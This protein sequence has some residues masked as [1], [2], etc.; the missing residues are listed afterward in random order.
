MELVNEAALE[1][2]K[3]FFI[4]DDC[5]AVVNLL[6]NYDVSKVS[7][8]QFKLFNCYFRT[9]R[10]NEALEL[11]KA[12]VK[13]ENLEDRV[14]WLVNLSKILYKN[15]DYEHAIIAANDALS[16]GS[17]VEYSD[18]TPSLFDRFYS[19][20]ALKRFTEAVSTISA[21]EQLRGQDFKIIE[22]YAAICDYAMKSND[23]A[24]AATYAKKALEL[25]TRAKINTFSPKLNFDYSEASLKTDNIDEA[26]DEAKFILNMKLEPEDRLHALNLASEIYIRQKQYKLAKPYLNE[27]IGSNFTSAYKDACKAKLEM[28]K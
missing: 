16:L 27:C 21:I 18:P 20:L 23:Y 25:Q 8:P 7:L 6:E 10:Y 13:D 14:E 12:H 9:A 19:L 24:I 3:E 15:K 28:I 22:A 26:L 11:A 2:T 1:L 17:A 5:T 4:K